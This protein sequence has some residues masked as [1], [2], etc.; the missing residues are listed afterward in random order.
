MRGLY[1]VAAVLGTVLPYGSFLPFFRENGL[2]LS[3][4]VGHA[5]ANPVAAGFGWDVMVSSVA[6]W[7]FLFAEGRRLSMKHRWLYLACNLLVGLSLALPLF[8][9]AREARLAI[10]PPDPR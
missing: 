9:Q 1:I 5:F 10:R 4:F 3:S 8:L 7:G 6:F 2:D